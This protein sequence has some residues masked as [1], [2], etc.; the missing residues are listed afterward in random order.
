MK[1]GKQEN[2]DRDTIA[3]DRNLTWNE[4][5]LKP[6]QSSS[7]FTLTTGYTRWSKSD[8]I[9]FYP[10]GTKDELS[11]YAQH[12]K[13]IELNATFYKMP[14][15]EQIL[16]W[17]AKV[18]TPFLFY[19]KLPAQISHYR[20]LKEVQE[21]LEDFAFAVS[22]F[23]E[24]LGTCFLQVPENFKSREKDKLFDLIEHFPAGIPLGIELRNEEWFS[25]PE[26]YKSYLT[27]MQERSFT[28]IITD[29]PGRRD[30]LHMH[31]SND[32]LFV[33]FVACDQA[34]DYER[35]DYWVDVVAELRALGLKKAV[36]FFHQKMGP[37]H[38][39]LGDYLFQQF[40]NYGI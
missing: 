37:A 6:F 30:V 9:G 27:R 21:K 13:S 35:L 15:R 33:R 23:E 40:E 3:F 20:R 26:L 38:P 34:V 1:F 19:P 25:D 11:Y 14:T 32:E 29:T 28:N 8:L 17:K 39:F 16:T 31:L 4:A 36:F 10:R 24:N 2:L 12:F 5:V 22:N 7:D 18:P